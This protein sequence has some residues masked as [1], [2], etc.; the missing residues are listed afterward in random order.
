MLLLL[1]VPLELLQLELVLR[2]HR[3]VNREGQGLKAFY[4]LSSFGSRYIR[5]REDKVLV[6][7]LRQA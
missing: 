1:R 7:S 6:D 4:P 5:P 3:L 2:C